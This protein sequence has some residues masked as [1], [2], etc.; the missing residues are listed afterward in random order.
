MDVLK[1]ILMIAF[2][3]YLVRQDIVIKNF[4]LHI[5]VKGI[6]IDVSAKEKN[7]PPSKVDRSNQR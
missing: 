2:A 6:D 1:I 4:K 3:I 5:G 7:G